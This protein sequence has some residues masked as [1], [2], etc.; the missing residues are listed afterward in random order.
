MECL[1]YIKQ[2]QF[3]QS[4]LGIDLRVA[5]H[6]ESYEIEEQCQVKVG[7]MG[8]SCANRESASELWYDISGY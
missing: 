1:K 4:I 3:R 6:Y 7:T 5:I 8:I 2:Y